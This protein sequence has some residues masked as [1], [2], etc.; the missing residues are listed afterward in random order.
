M[1]APHVTRRCSPAQCNGMG[2][3]GVWVS[4]RLDPGVNAPQSR[5]LSHA[6]ALYLPPAEGL[7]PQRQLFRT[8]RRPMALECTN[9]GWRGGGGELGIKLSKATLCIFCIV[10][11]PWRGR[12]M[13]K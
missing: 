10:T 2:A 11:C 3:L 8:P 13:V 7:S 6:S 4:E 1:P 5:G 9:P 12:N